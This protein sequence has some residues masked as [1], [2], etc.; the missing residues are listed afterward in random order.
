GHPAYRYIAQEMA[1]Q[2]TAVFPA[3]ERFFKFVD[4]DGYELG[5]LGQE[6]RSLEKLQAKGR[7]L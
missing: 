1:K 7:S 5:R 6:I 4:Y 2:V 3:F